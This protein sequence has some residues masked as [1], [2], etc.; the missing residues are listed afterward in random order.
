M[1]LPSRVVWQEGMYLAPHHFQAQSRYF[2]DALRFT[3]AS[4]WFQPYGFTGFSLDAEAL[5]NGTLS[6]IHARGI[7]PDGLSFDILESDSAPEA[8]SITDLFPPTND[9]LEVV[10]A[11]PEH[12]FNGPNCS[13]SDGSAAVATRYVAETRLFA[14]EGPLKEDR[15]VRIG[16]K[17][18]RLLLETE[19]RDGMADMPIA[20]ILRD[21][22]GNFVF[23]P[24]Y[25]PPCLQLSAS[26]PLMLIIARMVEILETK[27]RTM[28]SRSRRSQSSD[29]SPGEVVNFWLLHA[30]NSAVAVLRHLCVSK[31][32]HPEEA[33]LE[34]S[35]LAGALCTFALDAHPRTLPLYDHEHLSECFRT[36]DAQIRQYLET[37]VPTNCISIPLRKT[38]ECFYEGDIA[39]TRCFGRSR[40]VLGIYSKLGEAELITAVPQLVKICSSK[41]IGELVRRAIAGLPLTHLPAPPPSVPA[42]VDHQYFAMSRT[43]PFWDHIVQTRQ[44]GIYVPSEVPAPELEMFVVLDS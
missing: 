29:F 41:F 23:D 37:T 32:G 3:A 1:R 24:D 16:R 38:A 36:L 27:S 31:R 30:V 11:V 34:L 43:G 22:S 33:F 42:S 40:W 19:S 9:H 39:D 21:G 6:L 18:L 10:L 44:V 2:E 25:I 28:G 12:R 5:R 35:R 7:L 4:L 15:P 17:N 8:R 14:D 26:E 20:R 13:L